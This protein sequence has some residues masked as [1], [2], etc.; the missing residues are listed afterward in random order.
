MSNYIKNPGVVNVTPGILFVVN[1]YSKYFSIT[2]SSILLCVCGCP[3]WLY[4]ICYKIGLT[5]TSL[6]V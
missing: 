2:L 3:L 5:H 6:S 1:C 4:D